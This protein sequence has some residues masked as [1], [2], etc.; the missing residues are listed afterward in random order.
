MELHD[1]TDSNLAATPY[2][3]SIEDRQSRHEQHRRGRPHASATVKTANV[4]RDGNTAMSNGN[5]STATAKAISWRPATEAVDCH[6]IG[7]IRLHRRRD[8]CTARLSESLRAAKRHGW[9]GRALAVSSGAQRSAAR[10][11]SRS[12]AT[13]TEPFR[14]ACEVVARDAL[15][16]GQYRSCPRGHRQDM[17]ASERKEHSS[18][19]AVSHLLDG[20]EAAVSGATTARRWYLQ[21][22]SATGKQKSRF[23]RSDACSAGAAMVPASGSMNRSK[24]S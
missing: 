22:R 21:S 3:G 20:H 17:T 8:R 18:G 5:G 4:N 16:A 19:P 1:H 12:R 14:Q 24:S 13:P 9:I 6:W 15:E 2:D 7:T 10:R 11:K 23:S